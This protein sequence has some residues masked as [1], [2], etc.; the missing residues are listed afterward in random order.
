MQKVLLGIPSSS[1]LIPSE[2]VMNLLAQKKPDAGVG[3][4]FITRTLIDHARNMMAEV[5]LNEGYDYLWF[6]D[7]DTI[8]PLDALEN[9]L[10]LDKDIVIPAIPSRKYG[11]DRLCLFD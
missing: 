8:P 9:M 2:V 10:A 1:G 11:E 5:M 3:F 6:V 7:D 4:S